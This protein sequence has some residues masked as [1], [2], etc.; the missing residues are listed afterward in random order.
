MQLALSAHMC[1]QIYTHTHMR[2]H[3]HSVRI[4]RCSRERLPPAR[5]QVDRR[6]VV[7][8][9]RCASKCPLND[10]CFRFSVNLSNLFRGYV[11]LRENGV[12]AE[13]SR[14][15]RAGTSVIE[16]SQSMGEPD[17]RLSYLPFLS[18]L[19]RSAREG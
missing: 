1:A 15:P 4:R 8:R 9:R 12:N 18:Y 6:R 17:R 13:I 16:E 7:N 10:R 3:I 2:T 14:P 5:S 19:N 11:E